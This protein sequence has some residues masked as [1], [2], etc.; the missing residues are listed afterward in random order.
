MAGVRKAVFKRLLKK[1]WARAA[2]NK[3]KQYSLSSTVGTFVL[4]SAISAFSL[5]SDANP[6]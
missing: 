2:H 4:S 3:A 5:H 1:H 6:I